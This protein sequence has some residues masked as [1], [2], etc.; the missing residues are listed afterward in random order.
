MF[1]ALRI[2]LLL[3]IALALGACASTHV[4][5]TSGDVSDAKASTA[6]LPTLGASLGQGFDPLG[7]PSAAGAHAHDHAVADQPMS[8]ASRYTCPMHPEVVRDAPGSCP[9]CGMKLVLMKPNPEEKT[10]P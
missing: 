7:E 10:A 1:S 2:A 3:S 8:D 6:A 4:E 5:A 9:I